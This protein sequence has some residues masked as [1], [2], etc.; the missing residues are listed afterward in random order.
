MQAKANKSQGPKIE[1]SLGLP[2]QS[3][4]KETRFVNE[5]SDVLGMCME[6]H[7]ACH[8]LDIIEVT[9]NTMPAEYRVVCAP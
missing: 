4:G 5:L 8:R 1:P 2:K 3:A 9:G 6:S 7:A